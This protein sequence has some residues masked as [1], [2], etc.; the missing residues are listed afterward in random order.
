MGDIRFYSFIS[1]LFYVNHSILP[2]SWSK[3]HKKLK[4]T[5]SNLRKHLDKLL[6]RT[7]EGRAERL[8]VLVEVNGEL[9][10]LGNAFGRELEFLR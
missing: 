3:K 8:D 2:V 10:S 7:V 4:Q 1:S 6:E 5:L 9:S